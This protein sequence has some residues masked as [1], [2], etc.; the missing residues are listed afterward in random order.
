MNWKDM[1]GEWTNSVLE[2]KKIKMKNMGNSMRVIYRP[3]MFY[4][5]FERS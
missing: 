5:S 3:L 4:N 2:E 1:E